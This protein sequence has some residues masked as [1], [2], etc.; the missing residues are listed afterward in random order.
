MRDDL[1]HVQEVFWKW[2]LD[3]TLKYGPYDFLICN[4]DMVDGEGKKGTLDTAMTDVR[5]QA[6]AAEEILAH[7]NVPS[8]YT[9]LVRGSPFHTNGAGEYEDKIA[10]DIGC[11]IKDTQKIEVE[12][13]K[14]HSRHVV[15]RSDIPYGQATPLL[16]ELARVEAEAFRDAK[17]APDIIIRGHVHYSC[18]TGKHGRIAIDCP[19]LCLPTA[20]ANGRRYM[21]WEYDVGFG[22]LELDHD[23]EP[24]YHPVIMPMHDIHDGAYECVK[25]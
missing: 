24:I 8:D 4:G 12:G 20:S 16:K 7:A 19:C 9:F 11:S 1:R 22:V 25:W 21:A 2:Y 14:I 3:E 17:D 13:W 23:Y 6:E 15:G 10:D 5:K 18:F